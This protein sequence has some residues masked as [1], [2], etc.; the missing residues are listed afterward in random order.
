M[1]F[2][3][4]RPRQIIHLD[5]DAFY[6]TVEVLDNP[7]L[8]GR[9]VIVGG[10]SK[11]G[12]VSAA[13]YEARKYG[14]HSAQPMAE[15]RRRCPQGVFLPVRMRRY[16]EISEHIFGIFRRFSPLVEPIALDEA[17][18]DVT[19]LSR[20]FGSPEDIA[21]RIKRL[22]KEETGLTASAGTASTKLAAKIASDLEKPDGLVVVPPGR[23]KEFLDP[24][25]I[26]RLWGVGRTTRKALTLLGVETIGDL[27][28]LPEEV[29]VR[30]F[31][32]HGWKLHRLAQGLDEREVSPWRE[33][34]SLGA[35]ETF[36]EDILQ[37]EEAKR[38][39]LRLAVR[40]ARRLRRH[41][42]LGRTVILKVKYHDFKQITRSETLARPT[43]HAG[44]IFQTACRLLEKTAVGVRPVR[45]LGLSLSQLT[46]RDAAGQTLLFDEDGDRLKNRHLDRALDAIMD[47]YGEEAILPASLLPKPDGRR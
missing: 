38:E 35:E 42:F 12:V 28:R 40:S 15:A 25:P 26:S 17:F 41:G 29:L 30:K 14:I 8:K 46:R 21:R 2:E 4:V 22:I 23:E 3:H 32:D 6:A 37:V 36:P 5:M 44:E 34:K 1:S 31:G 33:V 27:G 11:R 19:G 16:K 7:G 24:L 20:L 43:D 39:V 10:T 45:L 47:K 13:S 9:P 18:L